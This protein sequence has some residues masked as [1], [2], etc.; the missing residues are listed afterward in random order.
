MTS[1]R[2]AWEV[3]ESA[4]PFLATADLGKLGGS[5][6]G[7]ILLDASEWELY[8]PSVRHPQ[9]VAV[10]IEKPCAETHLPASGTPSALAY[11]QAKPDTK[12]HQ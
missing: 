7:M 2:L 9:A 11:K 5:V 12:Q 8:P 4:A 10:T 3:D 1:A 6:A